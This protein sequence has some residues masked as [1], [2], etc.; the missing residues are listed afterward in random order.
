MRPELPSA[1]IAA[2]Y[3]VG[4]ST[5]VLAER[6]ETTRRTIT[7][8]LRASGVELRGPGQPKKRGGPLWCGCGHPGKYLMTYARDG[9]PQSIHR[10]CWEACRG[11]IPKGHII[12]HV[13][14]DV[15]NNRIENLACMSNGE[16]TALH[17]LTRNP[18]ASPDGCIGK[19]IL[20][21]PVNEGE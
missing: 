19:S 13:D 9:R 8:R 17:N 12:H 18:S 3:L 14:G 20:Q 1:E 6:H 10:A 11:E 2:G 5:N 7:S 15:S 16:H 21:P 4:D